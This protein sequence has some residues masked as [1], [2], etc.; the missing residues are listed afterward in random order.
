MKTI[1]KSH[2]LPT[3]N[4]YRLH[5]SSPSQINSAEDVA[6]EVELTLEKYPIHAKPVRP[7]MI[8]LT[9]GVERD[10]G[11]R[12][13]TRAE[14]VSYISE[15]E[16]CPGG[17][18]LLEEHLTGRKFWVHVCLLPNGNWRPLLIVHCGEQPVNAAETLR[19][20]DPIAFYAGHF[21]QLVQRG[22]FPALGDFI[23]RVISALKPQHPHLFTVRGVQLEPRTDRYRLTKCGYL[24]NAAVGASLS[25]TATGVSTE[26][27]L[28]S[29]HLDADYAAEPH[30]LW[31]MRAECRVFECLICWPHTNG[32][33]VS[34]NA[35]DHGAVP[36]E[37]SSVVEV[38]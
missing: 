2:S 30:H 32:R 10:C 8:T 20:G 5:F 38:G 25:Y 18:Y 12:V 6:A 31:A 35:F 14:L 11:K 15:R 13:E 4:F 36:E 22:Q 34:R 17:D 29:A 24:L 33:L 37:F 7:L 28:L 26:T 23:G 9:T 27:A 16:S 19:G 21:D 3:T 1:L